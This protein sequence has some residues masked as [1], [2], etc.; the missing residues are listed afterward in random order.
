MKDLRKYIIKIKPTSGLILSLIFLLAI[1]V[2][3]FASLAQLGVKLMTAASNEAP[4]AS[5]FGSMINMVGSFFYDLKVSPVYWRSLIALNNSIKF[6]YLG[7]HQINDVVIGKNGWLYYDS[8]GSISDYMGLSPYTDSE[9]SDLL[10]SISARRH[11]L[12]QKGIPLLLVIAPNKE[13]IYPEH[14]PDT[15]KKIHNLTRQDQLIEYLRSHSDIEI[16]DLRDAL[17]QAKI[18]RPTYYATDSHWNRYGAFIAYQEIMRKVSTY[19]PDVKPYPLSDFQITSSQTT[20]KDLTD[21]LLMRE[22][23]CDQS[24]EMT[25]KGQQPD[26][27]SN[28]RL[29]A[30]LIYCDSFTDALEPFLPPHFSGL[31]KFKNTPFNPAVLE[32]N[33]PDIVIYMMVERAVSLYFIAR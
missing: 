7:Y 32:Q 8:S 9:L 19:F 31:T 23:F 18:D 28:A 5:R 6:H 2:M 21:M 17:R 4:A 20:G 30:A 1:F 27:W 3:Y 24:I 29:P 13:T 16:L 22:E 15:I 14:L 11:L 26:S 12:S 33:K 10:N 25:Y